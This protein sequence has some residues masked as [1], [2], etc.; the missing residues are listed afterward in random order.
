MPGLFILILFAVL[1]WL[2]LR[3]QPAPT[4]QGLNCPA[5][6]GAVQASYLRCPHCGAT[7]KHHCPN[8]SRIIERSWTYCP[9]CSEMQGAGLSTTTNSGN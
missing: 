9:F 4:V 8:C 2:V 3:R 7:L 6:A 5:C 1:I